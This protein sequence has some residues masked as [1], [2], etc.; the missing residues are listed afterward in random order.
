MNEYNST[1]IYVG[2]IRPQ[3]FWRN[4]LFILHYRHTNL[5]SDQLLRKEI[6]LEGESGI[7]RI[8]VWFFLVGNLYLWK[9]IFAYLRVDLSWF[10][11]QSVYI[12]INRYIQIDMYPFGQFSRALGCQGSGNY[13]VSWEH[14]VSSTSRTVNCYELF[15]EIIC[16]KNQVNQIL[17]VL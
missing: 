9:P 15:E 13:P 1:C 3:I 5:Y 7:Y 6:Q 10:K 4:C 11:T 2:V 12:G 16:E 8:L 17:I 14:H